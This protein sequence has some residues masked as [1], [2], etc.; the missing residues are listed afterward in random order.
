MEPM[1]PK[2]GKTI[3]KGVQKLDE[4]DA[5]IDKMMAQ[6]AHILTEIRGSAHDAVVVFVD[7][8]GSSQ[9]KRDHENEPEVWVYKVRRLYDVVT[10]Y[11]QQL[12]GRVIKYIGDEVKGV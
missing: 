5:V 9:S 10:G 7:M 11:V 3:N 2:P 8:V 12:G 6:R 1:K 4:L